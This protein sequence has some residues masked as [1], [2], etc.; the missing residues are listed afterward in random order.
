MNDWLIDKK[1]NEYKILDTLVDIC[2][3]GCFNATLAQG[4][5]DNCT[6]CGL[7]LKKIESKLVICK[8]SQT[9]MDEINKRYETKNNNRNSSIQ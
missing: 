7:L 3:K 2:P 9:L 5:Q 4:I 8:A 6:T 1:G